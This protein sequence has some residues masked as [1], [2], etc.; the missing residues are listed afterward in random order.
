MRTTS[1]TINQQFHPLEEI[2]S[3]TVNTAHAAH[4]LNRQPQTMRYWASSESG[5]IRPVRCNGR[6][7]WKVSD[8]KAV[9]ELTE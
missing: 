9:L 3:P 8:I 5:P 6:L 1:T 4:Y 2:T 7:A